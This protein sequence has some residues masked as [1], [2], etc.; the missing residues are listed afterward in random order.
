MLKMLTKALFRTEVR[1]SLPAKDTHVGHIFI[2]NHISFWDPVLFASILPD[3]VYFVVNTQIAQQ[4]SFALKGKNFVTIDPFNPHSIRKLVQLVRGGTSICI[5]PEGRISV[6]GNLMKMY[7]GTGVI[8]Q[9]TGAQIVPVWF[10]GLQYAKWNYLKGK[11]AQKRFP[12]VVI[13][14]G[15]PFTLARIEGERLQAA[16]LRTATAIYDQLIALGYRA[17]EKHHVNLYDELVIAANRAPSQVIL[18]D[19]QNTL[20]YRQLLQKIKALS[21]VFERH[22]Q[23]ERVGLLLPTSLAHIVSLFACFRLGIVPAILNF[24]MGEDIIRSNCETAQLRTILTSKLFVEKA[25]L[26]TSIAHLNEHYQILY[27][28]DLRD[29]IGFVDKMNVLL[30][31]SSAKQARSARGNAL[32]LFTSGSESRPKGVELSHD[33]VL[34][35]VTQANLVIDLTMQDRI[36]NAMPMFH[37]FG[38]TVGTMLPILRNI[39]TVVYPSPL[40]Y[41]VI[42][43]IIYDKNCT[44]FFGTSTFLKGYARMANPYD[45]RSVRYVAAGAEKLQE[46]VR[47]TYLYRFGIRVYEGYGT[48]ET[49]PAVSI[50]HPLFLKWGSVGRLFPGIQA[51]VQPIEGI[52]DGGKLLLSGPNVMNGYWMYNQGF[53]PLEP[54]AQG[55]TWYDTGDVV[56]IDEEGYL[57]IKSRLKRFAKIGGEMVSLPTVED[58]V[59]SIRPDSQLAAV[60]IPCP[61]KGE[62]IVLFMTKKMTLKEIKKAIVARNVSSLLVPSEIVEI[63]AIPVLGSGK[64]NYAQ[65]QQ[66]ALETFHQQ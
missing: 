56:D 52:T 27:L 35:N 15:T 17:K 23:E 38:L 34:A 21:F 58:V 55:E 7:N 65:L 6:T 48:T 53:V 60:A 50:N 2:G 42:P 66:L 19:F 36:F 44:I 30:S 31:H 3:D 22:L 47:D 40:H 39:P 61:K 4:F 29:E 26:S 51:K 62:K 11:M 43:E 59:K 63:A 45:F 14:I 32:I 28:E 64:T 24:S 5:F 13:H 20:T 16:K 37:S 57:F 25:G 10:E 54:D 33:A 49:A 12:K 8:A 46:D 18:D 9:R 1:G 41:K